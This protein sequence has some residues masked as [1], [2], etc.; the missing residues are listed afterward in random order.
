MWLVQGMYINV[1]SVHWDK[2]LRRRSRSIRPLYSLLYSSLSSWRPCHVSFT[3]EIPGKTSIA[4]DLVIIADSQEALAIWKEAM[5]KKGLMV[6]TGETTVMLCGT[7]L[8]L[9]QSSGEWPCADF[10]YII[11]VIF[12]GVL[13]QW[14]QTLGT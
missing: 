13:L 3:L 8:D 2:S 6:N 10:I 7:G 14:L 9:L 5:Q 11:R 1:R 12:T 4:E